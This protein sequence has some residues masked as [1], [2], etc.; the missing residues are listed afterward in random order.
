MVRIGGEYCCSLSV[1]GEEGNWLVRPVKDVVVMAILVGVIGVS[2]P[3]RR[4]VIARRHLVMFVAPL[5]VMMF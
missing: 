2:A 3:A 4:L 1:D 5:V